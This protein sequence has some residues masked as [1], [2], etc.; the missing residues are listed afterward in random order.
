MTELSHAIAALDALLPTAAGGL[1]E[2]VFLLVSRLLPLV[3]VDLLVQDDARR[4]PAH[5][6]RR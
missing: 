1:P 5:V 3:N 2:D 6:A 4:T